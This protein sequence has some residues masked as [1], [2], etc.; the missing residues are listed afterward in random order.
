MSEFPNHSNEVKASSSGENAEDFKLHDS[1]DQTERVEWLK[2]RG[3]EI[4]FP[5]DR[6]KES[7]D[8]SGPTR[9]TVL[10][11]I[12]WDTALP[13][14]EVVVEYSDSGAGD[15]LLHA[16][17]PYFQGESSNIDLSMFNETAKLQFGSSDLPKIS[18][19]TLSMLAQEGSVEAFPLSHACEDNNYTQV[20]LY[21]DE[22]GRLKNLPFNS[23]ASALANTCGLKNVQL[24]GDM[25]VARIRMFP[26]KGI[27]HE[28]FRLADLDSDAVWLRGIEKQNYEWGL[29]TNKVAMES[30]D[31]MDNKGEDKEN[32]Y[33]WH[34][35]V[36][37]VEVKYRLPAG[38][39]K[40]EISVS[41]KANSILITNKVTKGNL[42]E[43]KKLK[44][45]IR[46]DESTW[47]ITDDC[48][49]LT[50]EKVDDSVTWG[51]LI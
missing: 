22:V 50:M 16:L 35:T 38:V 23:R 49:E 30:R 13:Y 27:K 2:A 26:Q 15:R 20:N 37:G 41:F 46:P 12:P 45:N 18:T 6:K 25:Y 32:N 7:T 3:V 9:S 1:D 29:K 44:G 21:L 39:T 11:L 24:A 31:T 51:S 36:M 43:I 4:E 28:N 48:I 42:L 33:T 10:V 40:K 47:T 14:R 5:E 8:S 34:E 17:K 19:N